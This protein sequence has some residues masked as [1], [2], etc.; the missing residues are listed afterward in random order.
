MEA[1]INNI[2]YVYFFSCVVILNY[3][4]FSKNQKITLIY[5]T[6]FAM[7]LCTDTRV[8]VTLVVLVLFMFV[9][10]EYLTLD[11]VK[12]R[13]L[14]R[15]GDKFLDFLYEF[16]FQDAGIWICLTIILSNRSC[17][18]WIKLKTNSVMLFYLI[19]FVF[20]F[21]SVHRLCTNKF[22]MKSFADIKNYFDQYV[23]KNLYLKDEDVKCRLQMLADLEDRSYFI[24]QN[25]YNWISIDF[26]RYKLKK[27]TAEAKRKRFQNWRR[28]WKEYWKTAWKRGIRYCLRKL[29][30]MIVEQR[31]NMGICFRGFLRRVRGC[32]TLEMQFMRV[33]GLES[34]YNCVIRRKIFEFVYSYLFFSGLRRYYEQTVTQK[35][36]YFKEFILY[37]YIQVIPL[38]FNGVSFAGI[39]RIFQECKTENGDGLQFRD[40]PLEALYVSYLALTGAKVTLRRISLYP[41]VVRDYSLDLTLCAEYVKQIEKNREIP[42]RQALKR[43]VLLS[44]QKVQPLYLIHNAILPCAINGKYYGAPDWPGYGIKACRLFAGSVYARIWNEGFTSYAGT[45][46]DLLSCVKN[47]GER[48]ITRENAE[49]WIGQA[50]PGAVIRICDQISGNDSQGKF[51]H[52]Q[53]LVHKDA[54]GCVIYESRDD[55]TNLAYYTWQEYVDQYKK[56]VHFKYIKWPENTI[57]QR[58]IPNRISRV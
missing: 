29:W 58:R 32:S 23:E 47:D 45:D 40:Y 2:F 4:S 17:Y 57:A 5:I 37:V 1:F 36:N 11:K 39:A 28:K 26:L 9:L 38:E 53:I 48:K 52:S 41:Q 21:V 3:N 12:L 27:D 56:Y 25:S 6:T 44:G 7:K 20:F 10:E 35:K 30:E 51:M 24:R 43:E 16:L 42:S 13:L 54:F 34:G 19:E 46:D 22:A 50:E 49:K 33:K 14:T 15:I 18:E 31:R 55:E 8:S